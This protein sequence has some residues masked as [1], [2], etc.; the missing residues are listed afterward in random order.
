MKIPICLM[1]LAGAV[2]A[3]ELDKNF[4]TPPPAARPWCYW[5]WLNG[6]ASKE[7]IT[8]TVKESNPIMNIDPQFL[9]D[10]YVL[11]DSSPAKGAGKRTEAPELDFYEKNS[12]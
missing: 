8:R 6:A 11:K 3:S 12:N 1:M 4:E 5:W 10:N 2:F 7:G 9:N